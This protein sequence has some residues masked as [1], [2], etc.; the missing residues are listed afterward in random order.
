MH[1]FIVQGR[2]GGGDSSLALGVPCA[3]AARSSPM[4][5]MFS[6]GDVHQ[7]RRA[8]HSHLAAF[9]RKQKNDTTVISRMGHYKGTCC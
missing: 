6:P 5:L 1:V 4:S 3:Y 9:R 7:R 2:G 8:H